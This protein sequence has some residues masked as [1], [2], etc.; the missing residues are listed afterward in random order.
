MG[1]KTKFASQFDVVDG[2]SDPVIGFV[3]TN[4]LLLE[5]EGRY[6]YFPLCFVDGKC[7]KFDVSMATVIGHVEFV[8]A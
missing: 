7:D 2:Y 5:D 6:N 4:V 3:K 8:R 1:P